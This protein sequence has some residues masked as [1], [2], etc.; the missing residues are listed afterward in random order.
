MTGKWAQANPNL[1]KKMAQYG[2]QL[3][4]HSYDHPSFTGNS[5]K[6]GVLSWK[7]RAFEINQADSVVRSISGVSTKPYFRPPYGDY[8]DALLREASALGYGYMAMWTFDSLGWKGI[9][10]ASII[11]R[12]VSMA[13]PGAIILMHV[14]SQS[15]DGPA[16]PA[17]VSA[18]QKKGYRFVTLDQM[19]KNKL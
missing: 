8:D 15:Q 17:I 5:T 7:Q 12:C 2:E 14:G 4:N 16:V 3:I 1:V 9:S 10:Q 19:V 18:L 13:T 6:T 11:S